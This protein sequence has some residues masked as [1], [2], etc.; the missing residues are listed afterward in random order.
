MSTWV[1]KGFPRIGGGTTRYRLNMSAPAVR[2]TGSM[3]RLSAPVRL[4]GTAARASYTLGAAGM[5]V[6]RPLTFASKDMAQKARVTGHS[7]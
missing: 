4:T 2:A 1:D 7:Y 6:V 5:A 3:A